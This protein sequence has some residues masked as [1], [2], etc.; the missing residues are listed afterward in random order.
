M[1]PALRIQLHILTDFVNLELTIKTILKGQSKNPQNKQ[2]V[3]C[4]LFPSFDD[5]QVSVLQQ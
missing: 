3:S 2:T 1:I 4:I 5:V